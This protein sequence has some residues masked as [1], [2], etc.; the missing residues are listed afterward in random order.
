MASCEKCWKDAGGDYARYMELLSYRNC[1][2]E[3]QAGEHA[4]TCS[5]CDRK[6]IHQHTN[7]CVVCGLRIEHRLTAEVQNGKR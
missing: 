5:A 7:Q 2:P 1:T 6:T 3:E 4:Y